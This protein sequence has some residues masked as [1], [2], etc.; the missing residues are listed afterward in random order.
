MRLPLQIWRVPV[1]IGAFV[2]IAALPLSAGVYYWVDENGVKH[3]SNVTPSEEGGQVQ[4]LE[5]VPLD[6][7]DQSGPAE[8]L[9]SEPAEPFQG[10]KAEPGQRKPASPAADQPAAPAQPSAG[11]GSQTETPA[12]EEQSG[13]TPPADTEPPSPVLT[14]QDEIVQNE[15]S[16]VR[17]LQ[18]QLEQNS[19]QRDAIIESERARLSG[20]LEELQKIPVSE[21][22]SQ[23]NKTRAM[24]YYRYRLEALQN[25][26][27]DYFAYGDSDLD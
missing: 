27:D 3:Y 16:T 9:P 13:E 23:R 8:P 12:A 14:R 11:A 7:P 1:A 10:E 24:G 26:P 18:R 4:Q 20:A 19:S 6:A 25:A 15:K 2:L 17:E 21:F 5:E 22:G